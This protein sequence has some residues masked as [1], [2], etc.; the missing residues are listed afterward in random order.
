MLSTETR[1]CI[2]IA[3]NKFIKNCPCVRGDFFFSTSLQD[4]F[5]MP[6]HSDIQNIG[7]K[8]HKFIK[9]ISHVKSNLP[10]VNIKIISHLLC[11]L[12]K[13]SST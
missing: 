5:W 8:N 2:K 6:I 3:M 1:K 9:N 12:Q 13:K 4:F 11:G 10:T 7:I